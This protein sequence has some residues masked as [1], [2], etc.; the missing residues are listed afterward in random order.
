MSTEIELN[1]KHAEKPH[2]DSKPTATTFVIDSKNN[3]MKVHDDQFLLE[4]YCKTKYFILHI[5]KTQ[6]PL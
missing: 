4:M 6:C 3:L 5:N 1:R 2:S